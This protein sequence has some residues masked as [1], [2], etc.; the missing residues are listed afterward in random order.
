MSK[1]NT[2]PSI[3][4]DTPNTIPSITPN[5]IPSITPNT[6]SSPILHI[7]HQCLQNL[8]KINPEKSVYFQELEGRLFNI[9]GQP[10]SL[11][12][13]MTMYYR[14]Y[15]QLY[16]NLK[17]FC[18]ELTQKYKPSEL[19][20]LSETELN[21]IVK[22]EREHN[23][24]QHRLYKKILAQGVEND[25]DDDDDGDGDDGDKNNK[26]GEIITNRCGKCKNT[27]H[28][29]IIPRQL[30]GGDEPMSLLITCNMCGNNWRIG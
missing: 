23:I 12:H 5:T 11:Q 20:Y 2:I 30:R 4:P 18:N 21:P 16:Y 17:L 15:I 3:T 28:L 10:S 25:D 13:I 6:I 22:A 26:S 1:T 9:C 19:V 14:K 7:R 8:C 24:E 27:K 29:T